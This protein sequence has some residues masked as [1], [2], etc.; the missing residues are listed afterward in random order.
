MSCGRLEVAGG[1]PAASASRRMPPFGDPITFGFES[2]QV[3]RNQKNR[4]S[5]L[6]GGSLLCY[7]LIQGRNWRVCQIIKF[8]PTLLSETGSSL[9]EATGSGGL[10]QFAGKG[11]FL[12]A[13]PLWAELG[14]GYRGRPHKRLASAVGH[15]PV[16]LH[17]LLMAAI[18]QQ[19]SFMRAYSLVSKVPRLVIR[20]L[21]N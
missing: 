20:P 3:H 9:A 7:G 1:H 6:T 19:R 11:R 8:R 14:R 4:S 5:H 21:R 12:R 13:G 10:C 17:A 2:H 16:R 15:R 18:S